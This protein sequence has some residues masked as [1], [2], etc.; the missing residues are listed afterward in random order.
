MRPVAAY[1]ARSV[2]YVWIWLGF[3][4][5]DNAICYALLVLWM[6]SCFYT[7]GQALRY[8]LSNSPVGGTSRTLDNVT[9]G[10]VCQV[11]ALGAKSAVSDFI[12]LF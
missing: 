7:I 1:V 6:K 11:V 9:F 5:E 4:S 10:R 3:F 2:V 8:V 12:S